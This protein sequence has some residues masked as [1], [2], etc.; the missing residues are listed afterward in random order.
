MLRR[1]TYASVFSAVVRGDWQTS[2]PVSSVDVRGGT[3]GRTLC[4]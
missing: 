2:I 4:K 3:T 1:R